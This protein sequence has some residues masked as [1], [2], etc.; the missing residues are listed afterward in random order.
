MIIIKYFL[1]KN[2]VLTKSFRSNIQ[3]LWAKFP[4]LVNKQDIWVPNK[5]SQAVT[6]TDIPIDYN[7]VLWIDLINHFLSAI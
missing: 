4:Y 2:S 3:T 1:Y 5:T 7:R 6:R